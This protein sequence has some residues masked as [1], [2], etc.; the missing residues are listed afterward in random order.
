MCQKWQKNEQNM[1][2]NKKNKTVQMYLK[3]DVWMELLC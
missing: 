1:Q 3:L 2:I